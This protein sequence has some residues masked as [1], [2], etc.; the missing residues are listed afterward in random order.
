M[1]KL[2]GDIGD[3]SAWQGGLSALSA[4]VHDR[5]S[6]TSPP[7]TVAAF[8]GDSD[9]YVADFVYKWAPAGNP[10]Q[11]NLKL[12]TEF[13]YRREQGDVALREGGSAALLGYKGRQS[14]WYAQAVYQFVAHWRAG[15]RYDRLTADNRLQVLE[16]SGFSSS[17]DAIAKSGFAD[18]G[19]DP[20]R[21]SFMLDWSPSE[22][23]RIRAQYNRDESRANASDDQWT[24]QY[25]MTLGSHGAHLF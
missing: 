4:E 17:A 2:G 18:R 24:L 16:T 10:D 15:L 9:L 1:L 7:D 5:A 19:H 8:S 11:R 13:F 3:S 20:Q 23:S 12:Q 21:W 25:I 22:F 14:G 6:A